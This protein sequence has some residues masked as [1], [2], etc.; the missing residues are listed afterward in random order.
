[1]GA[2]SLDAISPEG[3]RC[4]MPKYCSQ[5]TVFTY[6]P[7]FKS[8]VKRDEKPHIIKFGPESFDTT[9]GVILSQS[10]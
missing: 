9:Y 8:F 6:L 2:V 3:I 5:S 4:D 7:V 10:M 1:M